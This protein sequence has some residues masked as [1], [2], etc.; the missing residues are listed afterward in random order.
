MVAAGAL[1][2]VALVLAQLVRGGHKIKGVAAGG[3]ELAAW[4]DE[5]RWARH[6]D[7]ACCLRTRCF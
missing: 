2:S 5:L 1:A 3:D 4:V 7:A 6:R